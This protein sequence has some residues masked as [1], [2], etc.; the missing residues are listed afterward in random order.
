MKSFVYQE[1]KSFLCRMCIA[2]SRV[3]NNL[4][5]TYLLMAYY[6]P[7][8]ILGTRDTATNKTDKAT[9]HRAVLVVWKWWVGG[10]VRIGMLRRSWILDI[11]WS[12]SPQDSLFPWMWRVNGEESRTTRHCSTSD[13]AVTY[14][15]GKQGWAIRWGSGESSVVMLSLRCLLDLWVEIWYGPQIYMCGHQG[16][17]DT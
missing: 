8:T 9:A 17:S 10:G 4:I 2:N 1:T 11:R 15:D 14:W 3:Y 13:G 16:G 12:Q 5:H 6:V 7:S